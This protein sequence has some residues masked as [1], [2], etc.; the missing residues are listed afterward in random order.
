MLTVTKK[1][2]KKHNKIIA[3]AKTK[4]NTIDT[5]LSSALNGT[6][7][8][9]EEF[10]NIINEANI[11]KNI[12]ENIRELTVKLSSLERTTEPITKEKLTTL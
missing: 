9:H 7:I 10:T 8:S 12:K 3:L 1:R 11:Y 4:L 5:L 2:K 6:E